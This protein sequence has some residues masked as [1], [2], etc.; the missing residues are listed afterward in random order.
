VLSAGDEGRVLDAV[1]TLYRDHQVKLWVIYVRMAKER[2]TF[3]ETNID[4]ARTALA[5]PVGQQG[6]AVAA[7]RAAEGAIGQARTL[8]DAVDQAATN[9]QQARDGLPAALDELRADLT[10]ATNL[11][12]FGGP[13]LAAAVSS[14]TAA[15]NTP[16]ADSDPLGAFHNAVTADAELDRAIAAASDRKLAVED[17]RRR[18]DRTLTDAAARIDAASSFIT[19]RRGGVD[20]EA[21]TR[22]SEAQR[23]LDEARS[24]AAGDPERALV[25]AQTAADLGGRAMQQ[26]QASVQAWETR[27]PMSGGGSQ[28]G[29]VLGGILL[30]ELLRGAMSG[31]SHRGGYGGG[32]GGY[33]PGSYGGSSGSRRVSRG[34]RF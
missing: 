13:D 28:T 4:N 20:A 29:A 2:I 22:L 16:N 23:H 31:G 3:A 9:I 17:L 6:G 7:I 33:R 27:Q 14:A 26:A 24:L 11:T 10:S 5:Q 19:T 15:L 30:N 25:S 32:G 12:E 21:R 18:L 8:L 1:D 34:G